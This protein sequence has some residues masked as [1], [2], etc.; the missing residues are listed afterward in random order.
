MIRVLA[1]MPHFFR[2]HAADSGMAHGSNRDRLESRLEQFRYCLKQL[3]AVLE[4]VRFLL[5]SPGR[6]AHEQVE[7]IPQGI[8]GDIILVTA[9]DN[10]L[11]AEIS[12]KLPMQAM[13]WDGSPRELGYQCRRV[14]ARHLG[15]YDFYLFIEDDTTILDPGFFRKLVAFHRAHGEDKILLPNRYELYGTPHHAW[16]AYLDQPAF[17]NHSAPE[18]HGPAE[19]CLPN[20]DGEVVFRKTRDGLSGAYIITDSQLRRWIGQPDFHAPDPAAIAAGLDPLEL[21]QTPLG[22]SLPIYRPARQNLDFLE[23]HHVPNRLSALQTPSRRIT[24]HVNPMLRERLARHEAAN[25]SPP[26]DGKPIA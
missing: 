6:I 4:P 22:G 1:C 21:T 3:T 7:P 15:Q 12:A 25:T 13:I 11:V 2:R 10:N 18:R 14:F 26:P 8:S 20:F 19:L 23:V 24:D 17:P 9:P 5:G 16:R